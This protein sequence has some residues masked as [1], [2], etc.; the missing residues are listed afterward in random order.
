MAQTLDDSCIWRETSGAWD[1]VSMHNA[2]YTYS[3]TG[4]T[5]IGAMTY[6]KV[7]QSG[8]DSVQ[9]MVFPEPQPPTAEIM[10]R[11]MG[12]I[13]ED[14]AASAWYVVFAGQTSES[15]LYDFDLTIGEIIS[16][17]FGD[18][19]SNAVVTSIDDVT[20]DGQ[21]RARFH[22]SPW[23][24]FI[25][26]G[27]GANTGLFGYL[28]QF[29]ESGSCLETYYHGTDSLVVNGCTAIP[30]GLRDPIIPQASLSVFPNPTTGACSLGAA[31]SRTMVLVRDALGRIVL[32]QRT[33]VAGAI[34]LTMLDRGSYTIAIEEE[35]VR[36]I[37]E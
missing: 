21:V 23:G 31:Y 22:I 20:V 30:T 28:C 37:K 33:D 7:R 10:D 11:Y 8:V 25:V 2:R 15:L 32:V 5:L 17:T 16:G 29:F 1:G 34:D 24:R 36:V 19:G 35:I 3:I 9:V 13:R 12:A 4:D 27:V 14:V 26:E 6:K 18:C